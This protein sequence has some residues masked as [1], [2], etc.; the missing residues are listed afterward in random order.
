MTPQFKNPI[1]KTLILITLFYATTGRAQNWEWAKNALDTSA[2]NSQSI[3]V[4][5]ADKMGN[6]YAAGYFYGDTLIVGGLLLTSTFFGLTDDMLLVKYDT[7]G[8]VKWARRAGG[9]NEI[10]PYSMVTDDSG[11]VYACGYF[12]CD[13]AR[14]GGVTIYDPGEDGNMFLVKYDSSGNA[15]WAITAQPSGTGNAEAAAVTIST[16]GHIYICGTYQSATLT[17]GTT[18]LA[19]AG[20]VDIFLAEF[21]A[22]GNVI[23]AKTTGGSGPDIVNAITTDA[24]GNIYLSGSTSSSSFVFGATSLTTSSG[25]FILLKY[26]ASGNPI[27]A[28]GSGADV[29]DIATQVASDAACNVYLT[30]NF[31][32][33][34]L[35]IGSTTLSNIRTPYSDIFI[36]KYDSSGNNLWAKS[37]GSDSSDLSMAM[38]IDDSGFVYITGVFV[39][40]T[41]SFG[42][43]TLSRDSVKS[44]VVKYDQAGGVVWTANGIGNT[45][46]SNSICADGAGN[47][48]NA[49][50]FSNPTVNFG[51]NSLSDPIAPMSYDLFLAKMNFPM[52]ATTFVPN[53]ALM[54]DDYIVFPNPATASLSIISVGKPIRKMTIN[55]LTGQLVFTKEDNAYEEQ[56]D[57]SIL[58]AGVYFLGI[59]G[60]EVRRF[61]KE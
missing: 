39:G 59:N 11:N 53:R 35:T 47:I 46:A 33:P 55:S 56:V 34:A 60:I 10:F 57:I 23:W 26:N 15:V 41:I 13:T 25:Q 42:S 58:P 31:E 24:A 4:V 36:A 9:R 22:A 16:T 3:N 43:T 29:N 45:I 38:A 52:P 20:S 54:Q 7:S 12:N 40:H 6:V 44:F 19:S 14:F 5:S 48:Y 8:N 27:W 49:G 50:S 32:D 28:R 37:A 51:I 30:G 21:D 61:V 1:F 17:I 2:G 18:T